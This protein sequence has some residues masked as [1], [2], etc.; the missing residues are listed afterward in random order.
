MDEVPRNLIDIRGATM[1]Y[2]GGRLTVAS[3]LSCSRLAE[4]GDSVE[5]ADA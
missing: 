1:V 4:G 3:S 5:G 2:S